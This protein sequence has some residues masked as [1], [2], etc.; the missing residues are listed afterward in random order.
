M[1]VSPPWMK[2]MKAVKAVKATKAGKGRGSRKG[3]AASGSNADPDPLDPDV[4]Y[5]GENA[6]CFGG[7][8]AKWPKGREPKRRGKGNHGDEDPPVKWKPKRMQKMQYEEKYGEM[9]ETA[10]DE[11]CEARRNYTDKVYEL[12]G[13][14]DPTPLEGPPWE[15]AMQA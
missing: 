14:E 10:W 13:N 7:Q 11:M 4:L 6:G 3:G 12:T 9:F 2:A 8:F 5:F 1:K 15:E